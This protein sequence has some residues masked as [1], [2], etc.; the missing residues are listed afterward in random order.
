M[1]YLGSYRP[2]AGLI[3]NSIPQLDESMVSKKIEKDHSGWLDHY[4]E[5]SFKNSAELAK[6]IMC[7]VH[8]RYGKIHWATRTKIKGYVGGFIPYGERY[9]DEGST[10]VF[11]NKKYYNIPDN[12]LFEPTV[13]EYELYFKKEIEKGVPVIERKHNKQINSEIIL[14]Q[15]RKS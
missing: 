10:W 4:W 5:Y 2:G 8:I 12:L 13:E 6:P 7:K 9:L 11:I 14:I 15:M 1:D 3:N